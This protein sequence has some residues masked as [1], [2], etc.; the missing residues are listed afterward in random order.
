[1]LFTCKIIAMAAVLFFLAPNVTHSYL[2]SLPLEQGL[3]FAA[4]PV[5]FTSFG[6]HGS[7]PAIVKY[8]DGHTKSLKLVMLVGSA[9]PL[10]VYLFWQIVTLGVVDQST[11]VNNQGLGALILLLQQTVSAGAISQA[12]G[13]FA[14]LALLTSFLGVSL[15]LFQFLGDTFKSSDAISSRLLVALTT[16]TPP[17]MFALFYPEGF[18][19]ALGYAAVALVILAIF[20]PVALVHKVRKQPIQ[21]DSYRVIGGSQGLVVCALMGVA[22]VVAQGLIVVGILPSL[23]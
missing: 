15:G 22:I 8:L 4:I 1:M 9:I 2:L 18:I 7:I 5:I 14:D 21:G 19:A 17:L 23:G 20:L 13:I 11:M 16:F 3:L 10:M 6:F 12:I